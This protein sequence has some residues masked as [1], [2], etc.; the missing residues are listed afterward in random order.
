MIFVEDPRVSMTEGLNS[1]RVEVVIEGCFHGVAGVPIVA[2]LS[3][4]PSSVSMLFHSVKEL[5]LTEALEI[6]TL[7]RLV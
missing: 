4:I 6:E 5:A 3:T 1:A 7:I 2:S